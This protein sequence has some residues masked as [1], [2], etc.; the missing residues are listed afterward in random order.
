[1]FDVLK[2]DDVKALRL[3]TGRINAGL[4]GGINLGTLARRTGERSMR[5]AS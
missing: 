1:V 5:H 2:P 3:V 4:F